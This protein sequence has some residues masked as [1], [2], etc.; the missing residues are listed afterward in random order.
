MSRFF[1][2]PGARQKDYYSQVLQLVVVPVSADVGTTLLPLQENIGVKRYV[3]IERQ[4]EINLH[5]PEP[6]GGSGQQQLGLGLGPEET[7][8]PGGQQQQT[9]DP[10]VGGQ[11]GRGVGGERGGA[12]W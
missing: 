2:F 11:G 6:T 5:S 4:N 3:S 1:C 9:V 12:G 7:A 10:G 8:P